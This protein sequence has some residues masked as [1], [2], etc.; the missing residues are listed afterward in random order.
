M[1]KKIALSIVAVVLLIG[2]QSLIAQERD[3]D[4]PRG[5]EVR[6]RDRPAERQAVIRDRGER[7]ERGQAEQGERERARRGDQPVPE[8]PMRMEGRRQ[9][10]LPAEPLGIEL[11]QKDLGRWLDALTTAYRQNDREKMGEIIRQMHQLRQQWQARGKVSP[12]PPRGYLQVPKKV[13]KL[14]P[15]AEK[16]APKLAEKAP[17]AA[18]K[19]PQAWKGWQGRFRAGPPE[20]G[21]RYWRGWCPRWGA[22]AGQG[23]AFQRRGFGWWRQQGPQ[24]TLRDRPAAPAP[25]QDVPAP[26]SPER[27]RGFG[28]WRQQG[29]QPPVMQRPAVPAPPEDAVKPMLPEPLRG[30]ARRGWRPP[31]LNAPEAGGP[32]P[33]PELAEPRR[34]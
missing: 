19:H 27:P 18:K 15:G 2:T 29:P 31:V 12:E 6:D 7:A 1:C 17:R 24:P 21:R 34:D 11:G 4:R 30:P 20:W 23:G 9:P 28:W 13:E 5:D 25:P 8:P 33:G 3:A 16:K 32:G 14:R 26:M 22:M 10:A